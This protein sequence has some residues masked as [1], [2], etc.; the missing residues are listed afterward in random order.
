MQINKTIKILFYLLILIQGCTDRLLAQPNNY[1]TVSFNS[2]ASLLAGAVVGGNSGITSIYYNPAGIIDVQDKM[3]ALNANLFNLSK[4]YYKNALG[5]GNDLDYLNFTVKPRFVSFQYKAP[6]NENIVFQFA[7]FNRNSSKVSMYDQIT[8]NV[9]L[10]RP[11]INEIYTGYFDFSKNYIDTWGGF[12]MAYKISNKFTIGISSL[13]SYKDFKYLKSIGIYINPLE[14]NLPDSISYYN[15]NSSDYER[16]NMF[17]VRFVGKLGFHLKMEK[18]SYGLNFT[19]PSLK[20]FG[21]ADV[22]RSITN[23]EIRYENNPV[24]DVFLNQS[25]TYLKSGFKEPFSVAFGIRY[26]GFDKL[27]SSYFTIEYFHKIDTYK[28]IDGTET[29]SKKYEPASDFLSFKHG[30]KS[31]LNI[32]IGLQFMQSEKIEWLYGFKTNFNPYKVSSE[33]I[34]QYVNEFSFSP[35][36][37]YHLSVG[38]KFN[39]KK[40]SLIVGV[41]YTLGISKNIEEFVNFAEPDVNLNQSLFLAGTL[42]KNMTL[43]TNM[44]GLYL[45]LTLGN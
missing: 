27:E 16:I 34:F 35:S 5:T 39:Y 9:R 29:I 4:T 24:E 2:E 25:A 3:L 44:L 21:K 45:G 41:E 15:S 43:R 36:D 32:A 12:G 30:A 7:L 20:L 22:T 1:W 11:E 17:D 6:N 14:E 37:Y 10:I 8:Q 28:A 33:N 31:V 42:N 18:I 38:S 13:V 19:F 23:T 26:T 40:L